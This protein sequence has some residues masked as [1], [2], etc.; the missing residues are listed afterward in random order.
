MNV[1]GLENA[2]Y[3]P[4]AFPM[5]YPNPDKSQSDRI[6]LKKSPFRRDI[7]DYMKVISHFYHKYL[8]T[9]QFSKN[10]CVDNSLPKTTLGPWLSEKL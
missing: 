10:H 2:I 3:F 8:V 1:L 4:F 7:D 9:N 5:A 6:A